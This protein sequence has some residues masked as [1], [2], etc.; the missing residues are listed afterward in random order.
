MGSGGM[1]DVVVLHAGAYFDSVTLMQVSAELN[2]WPGVD[3]ALLAM[4]T[5]LNVDLLTDLG[6][7]TGALGSAAST[8]L[9]VA[10]RAADTG[11]AEAAV[12]ASHRLLHERDFPPGA[13]TAGQRPA[14]SVAS[15]ARRRPDA[16]VALVSVPGAHAFAEAM[17]ALAAGLHVV[18]FSDNV[19]VEQEILLKEEA[20]RC[21]LMALGPD[22]GTVVLGGVGFGFANVLQPGPVSLVAAS[23]TGAQQVCALL[24]AAGVGVT[25]VLGVGG[26]DLTAAV[27]G[28]ATRRALRLLDQDSGTQVIGLVA[29]SADRHV[30]EQVAELATSLHTKVVPVYADRPGDDLTAG[31]DRLLE[32][33]GVPVPQPRRWPPTPSP[34][35]PGVLRALYSGG[36]LCQEALVIAEA[37]LDPGLIATNLGGRVVE[38]SAPG[39]LFVDFGDDSLT[40]GRPHPMIDWRLRADQIAADARRPDVTV[41]LLDVVLGLGAHPDPAAEL[42][43]TITAARIAAATQGRHVGVVVTL[44]GTSSDPQGLDSQARTLAAAGAD[45]HLSNASAARRAVRLALAGSR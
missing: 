18:V 22:C 6:F 25:H 39:H 32:A 11:S 10:L 44:V 29:K 45:V 24:D 14:A 40:A 2:R 15:A 3:T 31:S 34:V 21:G 28:R 35:G 30:A 36:T 27:G 8:D 4:A 9:V 37:D 20:E 38:L 12:A 13:P 33:L 1:I 17:D 23:G 26:R 19:P 16:G 42:A 41:M 5:P 7:D 43:P